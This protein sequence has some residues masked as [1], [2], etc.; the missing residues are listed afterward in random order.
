VNNVISIFGK[1][2]RETIV[3]KCLLK[4]INAGAK[5][6]KNPGSDLLQSPGCMFVIKVLRDETVGYKL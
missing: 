6:N 3:C 1:V 4:K 2:R 5:K